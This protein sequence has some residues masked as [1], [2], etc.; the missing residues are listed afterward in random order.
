MEVQQ[1]QICTLIE[2]MFYVGYNK[3]EMHI[4][5]FLTDNGKNRKF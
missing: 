2:M 4:Y 3:E 1:F 5:N